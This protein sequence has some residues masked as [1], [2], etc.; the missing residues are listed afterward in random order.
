MTHLDRL[1]SG[2]IYFKGDFIEGC[3]GITEGKISF[4]GKEVNAPTYDEKDDF[5]NLPVVAG[6]IDIHAHLRGLGL[7]HKEDF[8]TGTSAA[9]AGGFTLVL[10][11]PNTVPPTNTR[12]RVMEKMEEAAD[13]IIIDVGLYFGRPEDVKELMRLLETPAIGLKLYPEDYCGEGR[14]EI[15]KISKALLS[16][17]KKLVFHPEDLGIVE[18]SRS[19]YPVEL[20]GVDKHGFIRPIEAELSALNAFR[21]ISGAGA[22]ATHLT[23]VKSI[24]NARTN[25]FT[26]DVCVNHLTLSEEDLFRMGS[27]CKV[28]PPLR[29]KEESNMLVWSLNRGEVRILGTDHAPHTL[30]EKRGILYDE[31]PSGMPGFETALSALLD[32]AGRGGLNLHRVLEAFTRG[33]AEFLGDDGLGVINEGCAANLTIF[34]PKEE[35]VVKPEEFYTKA[36]FSPFS[37]RVLRGRVKATMLRGEFVYR[38]GE[39]AVPKGFGRIYGTKR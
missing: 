18:S 34:D 37:N 28:N 21:S 11:M 36:K 13:Q 23:T 33:P 19:K 4:I 17:G 26:F 5:G 24:R 2:R 1:V 27:I 16:A 38:E 32:I 3:V 31:I 25:G 29:S 6:L 12:S 39:I 35:W 20:K 9:A 8:Q 14:N 7:K 10:D 30:E 22:H 15:A